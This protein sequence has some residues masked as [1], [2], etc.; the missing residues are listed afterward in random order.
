MSTG[1]IDIPIRHGY[2]LN[3]DDD[4]SRNNEVLS[5]SYPPTCRELVK[6]R[7]RN[8]N[9][10]HSY[11][12]PVY[13]ENQKVFPTRRCAY[14]IAV[15]SPQLF[16]SCGAEKISEDLYVLKRSYDGTCT[17]ETSAVIGVGKKLLKELFDSDSLLYVS[18]RTTPILSLVPG[19]EKLS[20]YKLTALKYL[21][22]FF[23]FVYDNEVVLFN[24]EPKGQ[25][26]TEKLYPSANIC[27]PGGGLE[28]QDGYCYERCARR[29]FFEETHIKLPKCQRFETYHQAEIHL[30]GQAIYVFYVEN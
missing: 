1:I 26:H 21:S 17:G 8:Y 14:V 4:Y 18:L 30:P 2:P 23:Y 10:N 27:I 20:P 28:S 7:N 13:S 6:Y 29:E 19:I 3:N 9:C 5:A 24:I 11:S 15:M 12:A 22:K 16:T 25:D